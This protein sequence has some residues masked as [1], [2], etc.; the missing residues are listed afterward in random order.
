V[1]HAQGTMNSVDFKASSSIAK[2]SGGDLALALGGELRRERQVYHQSEALANDLILG[3]TSQGP[4]AEFGRARNVGGVFAEVSAPVTK[5]L[6]LQGALRY[7]RYQ[8]TGGALSPKLGLRYAP[9]KELLL[10]GSVGSGFRAPSLSD[11][12]RPVSQSS[13]ATL[14][15]PVCMAA[16]A[17]NTVT[18]CSDVWTTYQYSNA[19][20][21]PEKSRQFS[22]GAVYEPRP[23]VSVNLDYWN[24][25]KR[26]LISNLGVDV[27]L[28]NLD[29]YGS[30]VHRREDSWID[31]IDLVK[32]NRGRQ[33]IAGL[34]LGVALSGLK[35]DLGTWGL[36]LNGTLTLDCKQQTGDGD[37]YVSNLGHFINDGVVQRW[38]HTATLDWE[39]GDFSA[40]LTNS[41]LARYTDQTIVG[42]PD[43]RVG[44]Y[45]L[46]DLTGAWSVSRALTLRAGVKNLFDTSPQ[47]SQQ[48]W[49]YLSGYDP[50]Y[51]DPRGRFAYVSAQY[52]F[53]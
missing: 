5:Q 48:A 50:S 36:R 40:A 14:V 27:I 2:L 12:Y 32:E 1:R 15:D 29:K 46:W 17:S 23:G 11:L 24:I 42:K 25:E 44:A 41:Y 31:H 7:E 6:E 21:K 47:F 13:S 33:K 18:D 16:D 30:L 22:F 51:T 28:S 8:V 10:R 38:R 20:L 35:S 9:A 37:P 49:F 43:R 34:D 39:R 52:R 53:Q 3:E 45:S 26:N 19:K 4:E